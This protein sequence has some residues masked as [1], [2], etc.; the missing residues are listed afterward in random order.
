MPT[1]PS[2]RGTSVTCNLLFNIY[3]MMFVSESLPLRG[4]WRVAPEGATRR[5]HEIHQNYFYH[6]TVADNRVIRRDEPEEASEKETAADKR[7]AAGS[8]YTAD[9]VYK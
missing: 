5:N 3:D 4:R 6:H 8:G 1:S 9:N 7:A 2:R